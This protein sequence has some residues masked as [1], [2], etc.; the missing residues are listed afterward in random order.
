MPRLGTY[1]LDSALVGP[2]LQEG[3][4]ELLGDVSDL[5]A[6]CLYHFE[7][8]TRTVRTLKKRAK[9]TH[10]LMLA[11]VLSLYWEIW[12]KK[13]WRVFKHVFRSSCLVSLR[14][15]LSGLLRRTSEILWKMFSR[16]SASEA[17]SGWV[18][19]GA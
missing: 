4:E 3:R 12:L 16:I 10:N 9:G 17:P 7:A 1:Q 18:P 11:K 13:T 6:V 8:P 19:W 5:L 14:R 2:N 15:P